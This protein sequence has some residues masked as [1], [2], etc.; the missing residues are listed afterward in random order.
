MLEYCKSTQPQRS[1]CVIQTTGQRQ[2]C[3]S[4]R[5]TQILSNDSAEGAIVE[6]VPLLSCIRASCVGSLV[7]VYVSSLSAYS[8]DRT[9]KRYLLK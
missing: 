7:C 6:H 5:V 4:H 8:G 9:N 1:T 2:P 3:A